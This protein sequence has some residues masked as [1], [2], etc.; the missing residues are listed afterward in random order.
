MK[1]TYICRSPQKKACA[2]FFYL[3]IDFCYRVFGLFVTRGVQ[4]HGKRKFIW[5]HHKKIEPPPD[6][7][8]AF[9]GVQKPIK[10]IDE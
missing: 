6:F 4:K 10:N 8:M 7:L 5:A 1:V 9:L 3:F 2:Y